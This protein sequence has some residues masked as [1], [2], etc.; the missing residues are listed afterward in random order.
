MTV[1][2]KLGGH[3]IH[4]RYSRI[5]AG[6]AQDGLVVEGEKPMKRERPQIGEKKQ[7]GQEKR[8]EQK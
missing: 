3:K 7:S 2:I 8:R 1:R 6:C 4:R 5:F